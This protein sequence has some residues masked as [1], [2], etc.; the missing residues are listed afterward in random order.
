MGYLPSTVVMVYGPRDNDELEVI[1]ALLRAA[2][3]AAAPES[4]TEG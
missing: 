3:R 1:F 2:H 4:T